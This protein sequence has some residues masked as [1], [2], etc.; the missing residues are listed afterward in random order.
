MSSITKSASLSDIKSYKIKKTLKKELSDS[1]TGINIYPGVFSRIIRR[2]VQVSELILT[3]TPYFPHITGQTSLIFKDSRLNTFCHPLLTVTFPVNRRLVLL[4]TNFPYQSVNT[5]GTVKI[6]KKVSAPQ[7]AHDKEFGTLEIT[8]TFRY[9]FSAN[10]SHP[11]GIQGV[12]EKVSLK[13]VGNSCFIV[14]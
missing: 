7:V 2:S 4:L 8:P 13:P 1:I 6:E 10:N 12:E 5:P 3:Y 9:S 11:I 14:E